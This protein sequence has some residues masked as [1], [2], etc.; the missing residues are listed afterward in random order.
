MNNRNNLFVV[1]GTLMLILLSIYFVLAAESPDTLVFTQNTTLNYDSDGTVH[2]NWTAVSGGDGDTSYNI[3]IYADDSLYTSAV[4]SSETG[5]VFTNTTDANY[6]FTVEAVNATG[7]ANSTNISMIVDRTVPS[8]SYGTGVGDNNTGANRT[9]IFA[10]VTASDTNNNSLVFSLYNSTSLVNQTVYADSYATISINW[11]S[12][13]VE[14]YTYNVTA[15]DSA[16]NSNSTN[17]R[18]FYL[19]STVPTATASCTP[20]N[21]TDNGEQVTCTCSGSDSGSGIASSTAT[22]IST[23]STAGSFTYDCSVTNNAGL[24]AST[25]ATYIVSGGSGGSSGGGGGTTK[26][27]TFTKITP[28]N[29]SIM[30]NFDKEL[31]IKEIQINVNNPAQNV[32]ISVTK[33]DGKP[34]EVSVEKTGKVYQYMQIKTENLGNKLEKAVLKIKVKKS[35]ISEKSLDKDKIALFK[36]DENSKKWNELSTIYDSSDSTYDYFDVELTSFSYFA[37]SEKAVVEEEGGEVGVDTT[38]S[39]DLDKETRKLTWWWV[40]IVVLVVFVLYVIMT[41]G[42]KINSVLKKRS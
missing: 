32:K 34:A 23:T 9:W 21:P 16:T 19:D 13:P 8:L 33:Y 12:L 7:T 37:I 31:G 20:S 29:V 30:K 3:Y 1:F 2:L 22:S 35:W 15:N 11:T 18:T 40:V 27:N 17:T 36:F 25:T 4:N 26:S 39:G 41:R 28:G 42:K 10:N 5:Y 6:T 14:T 24:S 38:S